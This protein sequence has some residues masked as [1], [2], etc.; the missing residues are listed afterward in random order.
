MGH[1]VTWSVNLGPM[2]SLM[3]WATRACSSLPAMVRGLGVPDLRLMPAP[4]VI[5]MPL[6]ATVENKCNG[7][8]YNT[9][10]TEIKRKIKYIK[11]VTLVI[12]KI[13]HVGTYNGLLIYQSR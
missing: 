6:D 12:I 8:F 4:V 1:G 11:G 7:I 13:M 9:Y 5:L 2:I 3:V 10:I